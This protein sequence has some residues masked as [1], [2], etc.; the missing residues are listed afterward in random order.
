M[1]SLG[2]TYKKRDKLDLSCDFVVGFSLFILKFLQFLGLSMYKQE[3]MTLGQG[4]YYGW[5]I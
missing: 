2:N 1:T 5:I 3:E 4:G